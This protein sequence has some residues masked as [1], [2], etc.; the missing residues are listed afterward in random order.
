MNRSI[1]TTAL[2]FAGLILAIP[3]DRRALAQVT[4]AY[5]G[6]APYG[7][8]NPT[9]RYGYG[10]VAPNTAYT[11]PISSY[12]APLGSAYNQHW[13]RGRWET[14]QP[15]YYSPSGRVSTTTPETTAGYTPNTVFPSS[16]YGASALRPVV[17]TGY[18][19]AYPGYPT[20]AYSP[21]TTPSM[22]V[23]RPVLQAPVI[24]NYAPPNFYRTSYYP[25]P[26]TYYRPVVAQDPVTGQAVT[27]LQPCTDYEY[28]ARRQFSLFGSQ[29]NPTC[30]N[31]GPGYGRGYVGGV[32]GAAVAPGG[33]PPI[34]VAPTNPPP[35]GVY[36]PPS[37]GSVYPPP[38]TRIP[39]GVP[40]DNPPSLAPGDFRPGSIRGDTI[41]TEGDL[42]YHERRRTE[43]RGNYG[44]YDADPAGYEDDRAYGQPDRDGWR[45]VNPRR[46]APRDTV[47]DTLRKAPR[48]T[49]LEASDDDWRESDDSREY[50]ARQV[51]DDRRVEDDYQDEE[52]RVRRKVPTSDDEAD[53]DGWRN[54]E[55][56]YR[57]RSSSQVTEPG[58]RTE[59]KKPEVKT[60]PDP[61]KPDP[62]RFE[63]RLR[64]R[65]EPRLEE[66][67][68]GPALRGPKGQARNQRPRQTDR[69]EATDELEPTDG[70]DRAA[71]D[72]SSTRDL[73][74]TWEPRVSRPKAKVNPL[75]DDSIE[76][77]RLPRISTPPLL[78]TEDRSARR[79]SI[80]DAAENAADAGFAPVW[81]FVKVDWNRPKVARPK[82]EARPK[83][84]AR[85]E[86]ESL[87]RTQGAH[88]APLERIAS[89]DIAETEDDR[90]T[91]GPAAEEREVIV[92]AN[93]KRKQGYDDQWQSMRGS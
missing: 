4:G 12:R 13:D 59:V 22:Y 62:R 75:R 84:E 55:P 51:I 58:M 90:E 60:Q 25:T 71:I 1:A 6:L 47:R 11:P 42:Q 61:V 8:V 92:P 29:N 72:T 49:S 28:Q 46:S 93:P 24:D 50:R 52:P 10:Y 39:G 33:P 15:S 76:K 83:T 88:Q 27:V 77:P 2:L 65:V 17:P 21:L 54:V 89:P 73:P 53:R 38:G 20:T 56:G 3:T 81:A 64:P 63:Q 78:N 5:G 19:G 66:E 16:Y 80:G 57:G 35:S 91:L 34:M 67:P 86:V 68:S 32:P 79:P 7:N 14:L 18:A 41:N 9:A 26:V 74:T 40:A 31:C 87:P 23:G 44:E 30:T 85:R 36:G 43:Y 37:G 70:F 45:D 69:F 82:A 48:E